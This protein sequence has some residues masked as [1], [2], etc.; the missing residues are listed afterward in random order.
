MK[1]LRVRAYHAP[2]ILAGLVALAAP[3]SLPAQNDKVIT[4]SIG[5]KLTLIP[6]GRFVMGS[7]A[8]EE[9]RESEELQHEVTISKPF[10]LGVF[11]VTQ[12]QY[13]KVAVEGK[14]P[15]HFKQAS[16]DLPV[17]QVRW[18]DA[19]EFC[20]RLSNRAEEIK[21]GRVYR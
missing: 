6:A 13:E 5:V 11:E 7:P 3:Q 2:L 18:A 16:S 1:T 19:V 10:Y 12:K 17:E 15:A 20:N 21:E 4:N 9:E 14:N 8:D